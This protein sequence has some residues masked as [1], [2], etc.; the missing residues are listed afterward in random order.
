MTKLEEQDPRLVLKTAPPKAPKNL[1]P[2]ERL[3]LHVP[4]LVGKSVIAV[5]ATS[6]FGKTM[7]LAQ[8]RREALESGA[9]VAWLTL[10]SWDDESRFVHGLT[11][12]MQIGSGRPRFGQ[13]TLGSSDPRVGQHE[14]LTSWLAEVL[15][16]GSNVLLILDDVHLMPQ[17]NAASSLLYLL[18]N[19]PVNLKIVL[20]ARKSLAL[21]V[22]DLLSRGK[23]VSLDQEHL[24]FR[25]AETIAL[26]GARFGVR[27]DM[28]SC[29]RLHELTEGWPLGLQLAIA[30]VEKSSNVKDAIAR[31]FVHSG[32]IRRYFVE[33]LIDRLAPRDS[34]FLVSV[35]FIDALH[36]GLCTAITGDPNS[37]HILEHLCEVTPII[38]EGLGS[39]WRRLHP[40]ARE[41]LRERFEA[42][43]T[44]K[45]QPSMERAVQ[46][47]V[48]QNVYEEAA[49]LAIHTGQMEL[50]YDL[51]ERCLYD[52]L[53]TGQHFR[54]AA[55]IE[56]I[57]VSAMESRPQLRIV[58]AW[59]LAMS[60]RHVEAAALVAPILA[61]PSAGNNAHCESAEICATAA[62]LADDIDQAQRFMGPWF[63]YLA[64]QTGLLRIAGL[65]HLAL[66]TLYQG[67]PERARY[68]L[69]APDAGERDAY[70]SGWRDWVVGM[71]YVWEGQ[72][73]LAE[74][75]LRASLVHAE[76]ISGYRNPI[77]AMLSA[78]LAY[79]LW[80]RNKHDEITALLADRQD[81]IERHT[82][83]DSIILGHFAQARLA[84]ENG[85]ERRAVDLLE[86]LSALGESRGLHRLCIASLVGQ[87]RLHA[88]A[89]RRDACQTIAKRLDQ[90]I[91]SRGPQG[92]GSLMAVITIQRS[93]AY[94]HMY[95]V[96]HQW[97]K[98]IDEVDAVLPTVEA[99]RRGK[100]HLQLQ[101]IKA[102]ALKRTGLDGE[103]LLKEALSLAQMLG[104]ERIL[105]DT[106]PDLQAWARQIELPAAPILPAL[107]IPTHPPQKSRADAAISTSNLLTPKERDVLRLLARSMSNKEIALAMEIGGET[108]KWHLKNLFDKL[109]A[110]NRKHLLHRAQMLGLVDP[111]P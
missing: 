111:A 85:N 80:E 107:S 6:G 70:A 13:N 64:K 74:E 33:S 71:S 21:P 76:Q 4:E 27:V 110:A 5:Q 54:V 87:M 10:D 84:V 52:I 101:L 88:H 15:H 99:M 65:N 12:A 53:R 106:H 73:V 48:D 69:E 45:K 44:E 66:V 104:L 7:L 68:Y 18:H 36:P 93:L 77:A 96:Q 82:A 46:W 108:V 17:P 11:V 62:V 92:W 63:D 19:A 95:A 41:F 100:D 86:R 9:I 57:P 72:M 61:D 56:R 31:N 38:G 14:G 43:P 94:C 23:Y 58:V 22:A 24:R 2:R 28:D 25:R 34:E 102:L 91:A 40:L 1:L 98:V 97:N 55:W 89:Y 16:L 37:G 79:V 35:S 50:A 26:V 103:S 51:A 83:A 30:Q 67:K 42:L 59:T 109:G 49:R 47:L 39:E 32:D 3:S 60:D 20:S 105:V 29:A 90:A 78:T 75:A 81:V 8:W